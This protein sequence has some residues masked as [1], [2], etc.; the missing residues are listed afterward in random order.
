MPG[1]LAKVYLDAF[2]DQA[3][4][5]RVARIWPTANRQKATIEVRV[6]F[7]EPDE[8]LRPEMGAR[9]VFLPPGRE[10]AGETGEDRPERVIVIPEESLVRIDGQEGVFT[11][12]RDVATFK[13]LTLGERGGG[14]VTVELG[15]A[16]GERIV[17]A[18]P[19]ALHSGDRVRLAESP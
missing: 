15:L 6:T 2:P 17:L 3:Y 10:A 5:G 7:D 9:I 14:R 1:A 13:A 16:D 18:P 11:V 12:E 19:A 8:R 4:A